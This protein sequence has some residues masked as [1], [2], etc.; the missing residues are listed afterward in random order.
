VRGDEGVDELCVT[1][2]PAARGDVKPAMVAF[3]RRIRCTELTLM[4]FVAVVLV[5]YNVFSF[6][7]RREPTVRAAKAFPPP[8]TEAD[9]LA[10]G[11]Q[12]R[13]APRRVKMVLCGAT[14]T[15]NPE[16]P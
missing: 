10:R 6:T 9:Y 16:T 2:N 8:F 1:T 15:A 14:E 5:A 3:V 11:G 12:R 7:K 13:A 4:P